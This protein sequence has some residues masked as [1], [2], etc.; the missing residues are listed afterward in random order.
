MNAPLRRVLAANERVRDEDLAAELRIDVAYDD[1]AVLHDRQAVERHL[2]L[3]D[4]LRR[5]LLPVRIAVAALA[6]SRRRA[7]SS[8]SGSIFAT[9]RANSCD[10]STSSAA[11]THCGGFFASADDGCS[12]N[13]VCRAPM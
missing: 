3:R 8:H 9:V 6:Q 2:L 5:L 13:R 1:A 10:V 4:D 7:C 11:I 12:M